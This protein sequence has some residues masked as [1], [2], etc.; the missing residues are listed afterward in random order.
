MPI[1]PK[2][3]TDEIDKQITITTI[4][5]NSEEIDIKLASLENEYNQL[6]GI[7]PKIVDNYEQLQEELEKTEKN[8]SDF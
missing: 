7:T 4:E 1:K 3:W 5:Q 2:I 8:I 6:I